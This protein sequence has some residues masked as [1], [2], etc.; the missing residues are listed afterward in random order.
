MVWMN[1]ELP[2]YPEEDFSYTT[3]LEDTAYTLR[4]YY[5]RRMQ[6]WFMDL[7]LDDG[8]ELVM[9]VGLQHYYPINSD[10]QIEN[11]SGFF[12]L[13]PK[14]DG[15]DEAAKNPDKLSEYYQLFYMWK[16]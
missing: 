4:I 14:N 15:N 8:T 3:S 2:L 7:M 6:K 12:W 16:E 9:G 1:I 11:L 5:N 10:Y 13:Q